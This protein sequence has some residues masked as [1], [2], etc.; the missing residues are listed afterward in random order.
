MREVCSRGLHLTQQPIVLL[1]ASTI[2][3]KR[4]KGRAVIF[5]MVI[6]HVG[7]HNVPSLTLAD[8]GKTHTV[9]ACVSASGQVLPPF[10]VY[11]RKRAVPENIKEGVYP[12]TIFQISDNG[13][14]TKELFFE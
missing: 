9:N 14:I 6:A 1:F 5:S 7:Q 12:N 13:W 10:M 3:Q 4:S 2:C 11:P 8:R